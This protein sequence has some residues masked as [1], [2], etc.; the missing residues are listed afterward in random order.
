MKP[1]IRYSSLWSPVI[2]WCG[3]IYFLSGIPDLKIE[4]IGVWDLILRKMA[5]IFEFGLLG[6]FM[7]RALDG[8]VGK[9]EGTVLSV[10]FWAFFLSFLYAVS[11]EYHQYFV[12][13]RIPSA[14]DVF[15]DSA[16]I[17]L[18]L[19]AIKIRKKWKIKPANG[20][21]LFSLLVLCCFYLT[22][23]GPNYQFNR[24]KALE[25]KGQY[26]E[27]LMKYLRIAETNPDHP[28]AVE[29]LYRAGKLCQIKFKLYAKSTDI[30]FEL[31][32]KYPEATQIVHKAKAA[33]FNSPD[34][35][36]LVNDNLWVE[37]DS[38]TGGKNMQVEWHCSES[39][40]A[41]RQGV[42]KITK[43]YFAGRKPVSAVIRYY[44]ES[45]I[46]LREYA[47]ADTT[48]SQ[49]TVLLKYPFET[50]NTWVT[51]R[52]GRKIRATIVD[53]RASITAKAG[54]FDDCLKI[55]YEDLAIP[56]TFKY[57]YYA[58]D[59]GLILITVKGKHSKK[60]YR[61]SELLSCKLKEPRW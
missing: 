34:Y 25:K 31:I 4:S 61:N 32:K 11:D 30:F 9:R 1:F 16:G 42:F 48:S 6:A 54:V 50:G 58:P 21:A 36:P 43:K 18:A 51:E 2:L 52:D 46:E 23:C 28:S 55:R 60:E 17:L 44:T 10:S 37:G 20:P 33:I 12:P 35:F 26:N 14:R 41:S 5:H 3:V 22:A 8:S 59:T 24:A 53:N 47:S 57:E 27:A 19:T 39:T 38:E 40:G 29:S 15:F 56:G 49:Y 13:G 7:Y 45:S